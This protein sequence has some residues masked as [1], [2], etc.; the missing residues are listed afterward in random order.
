VSYDCLNIRNYDE[1]LRIFTILPFFGQLF[2]HVLRGIPEKVKLES[3]E[4]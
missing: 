3:D 1:K 4:S 2:K